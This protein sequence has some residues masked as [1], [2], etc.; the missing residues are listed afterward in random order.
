MRKYWTNRKVCKLN[1]NNLWLVYICN[2]SYP[3]LFVLGRI[4]CLSWDSSGDFIATGSVDAVRVWNVHTGH[5]LHKMT[6]GR[7]EAKKETIVWCLAVTD[8][9]TI[10]SGDSRYVGISS[11][12]SCKSVFEIRLT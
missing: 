9:F 6:T 4:L 8:D 2:L 10:I 11:F 5:A 12:K 3:L 7:D 1:L